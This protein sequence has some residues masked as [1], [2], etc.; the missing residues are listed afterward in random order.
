M[1]GKKGRPLAPCG[2]EGARQR[3]WKARETCKVCA[4]AHAE[5]K[6]AKYVA[7]PRLPKMLPLA[8]RNRDTV[9]Q[10]KLRRG[11][12]MDCGLV[13]DERTIVCIDFDHRDPQLKSFQISDMIGR[14]KCSVLIEEMAKCD[15]VCRNCHALRT[16]NQQHH[17]VTRS[18][19]YASP[20]LFD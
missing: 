2:T 14:V 4:H 9:R 5:R 7:K 12:C 16:H 6:R 10:E 8:V 3:H 15:A 13:I 19:I 11:A 1:T 17:L 18:I 20:T